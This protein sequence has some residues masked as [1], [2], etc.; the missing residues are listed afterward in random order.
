MWATSECLDQV[1]KKEK[2]FPRGETLEERVLL[3][4]LPRQ[5]CERRFRFLKEYVTE[6]HVNSTYALKQ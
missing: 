1:L 5:H 6:I 2:L 4:R 3:S